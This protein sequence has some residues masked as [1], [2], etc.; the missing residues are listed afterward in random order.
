VCIC[1]FMLH[2]CSSMHGTKTFK[3]N[4]VTH[5]LYGHSPENWRLWRASSYIQVYAVV[6]WHFHLWWPTNN[7]ISITTH[8]H[9]SIQLYPFSCLLQEFV[10]KQIPE[11]KCIFKKQIHKIKTRRDGKLHIQNLLLSRFCVGS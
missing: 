7:H 8:T 2:N 10:M 4:K 5:I 1:W 11:V 3:K 9:I 6:A